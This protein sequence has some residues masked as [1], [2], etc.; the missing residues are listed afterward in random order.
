M[1]TYQRLTDIEV[2]VA[3]PL[4][5]VAAVNDDPATEARTTRTAL[6]QV[7]A[8]AVSHGPCYVLFSGGRDSSLVL[9]LA[10]RVA[11]ELGAADPIP[12][13]ALYPGDEQAD[14][15][16]WQDLVLEHLGLTER[17]VFSVTDERSTL[18]ELATS[19][20]RRRGLVWPE[21]VH[22]QPLFFAQ[23][24]S[25]T[26]LTGEGGDAFL[27]GRRITPLYL[28][29]SRR[30]LPSAALLRA[31]AA[32]LLPEA[33]VRR[34]ARRT[35]ADRDLLPWLRPA[36]REILIADETALRGPLR[37][38][39]ATWAIH[40]QRTTRLGL[41][42][43]VVSAAE[44]GLTMRHPIAEA[45]VVAALAAEGGTWGFRGRTNLFRRLGADLLPDAVL[46]RRSKAAFNAS[47]WGER[48]RAFARD[49]TGGAFDPE[50]IDEELLQENWLSPRAHPVSYFLAQIAWLH[51]QGLP[52]VPRSAAAEARRGDP[53]PGTRRTAAPTA[54][55][56]RTP[57]RSPR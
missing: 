36:A 20:L 35:Y 17:I 10:A 56:P 22:T 50:L 18:G 34:Q 9:A 43:A 2:G 12:V 49:Y 23:L 55:G 3:A 33:A 15:T 42:N 54:A 1:L 40:H 57:G 6:E 46:A 19:H 41:D 32:A 24:G 27:E 48:E 7:V 29:R 26:V 4:G 25:G 14:E 47:R 38:D 51:Q 11:R 37:W 5:A 44:Y 8:D 53:A 21:A 16:E 45:S 30:R 39:A 28:L 13:T 52:Q 31:A